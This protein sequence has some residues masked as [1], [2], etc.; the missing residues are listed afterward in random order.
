[1]AKVSEAQIRANKKWN[2]KNKER[3][4]YLKYRSEAKSFI[5]RFATDSDL[6]DLEK[7]I[8]EERKK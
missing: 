4:K 1:M 7:L 6:D 2:E 8:S 3:V 5:R